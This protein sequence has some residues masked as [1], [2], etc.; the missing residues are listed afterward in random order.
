MNTNNSSS[1]SVNSPKDG[2]VSVDTKRL[3]DFSRSIS[4]PPRADF[5]LDVSNF[6]A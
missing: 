6:R 2:N 4:A 3:Y 1:E 5:G